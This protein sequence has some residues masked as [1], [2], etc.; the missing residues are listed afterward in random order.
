MNTVLNSQNNFKK[1]F[2]LLSDENQILHISFKVFQ[3]RDV[4]NYIYIFY[5]NMY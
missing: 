1:L 5:K 2:L 4:L 3:A